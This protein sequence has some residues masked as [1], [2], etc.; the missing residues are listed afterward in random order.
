MTKYNFQQHLQESL[1]DPKFQKNW[2][3][4]EPEYQLS[5]KLIELR[6]KNK[7]SQVELA[8]KANT[9]QAIISRIESM[10]ANPSFETLKKIGAALN[11][12]LTINFISK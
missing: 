4:S 1:K 12:N 3:E 2:Q 9:T 6:L 10:S 7:M 11:C 5:C 8:Q